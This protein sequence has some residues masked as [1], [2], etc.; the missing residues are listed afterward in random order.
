[1][2]LSH[3]ADFPLTPITQE[4]RSIDNK[5]HKER[6]NHKSALRNKDTLDKIIKEDVECGFALPLPV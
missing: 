2:I 5:F 1:L 3:G 4:Q 6:G